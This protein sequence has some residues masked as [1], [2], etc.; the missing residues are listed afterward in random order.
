MR[1]RVEGS[2]RQ[3]DGRAGQAAETGKGTGWDRVAGEERDW[4][5]GG[6]G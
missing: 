1:G 4:G 2:I 5:K 6:G 3:V